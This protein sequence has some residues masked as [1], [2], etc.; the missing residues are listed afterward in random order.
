MARSEQDLQLLA[1]IVAVPGSC[2][3]RVQRT[4][5]QPDGLGVGVAAL[6][7]ACAARRYHAEASCGLTGL[8]EVAPRPDRSPCR[9]LGWRA[10]QRGR[11]ESGGACAGAAGL[12]GS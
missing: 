6:G 7:L 5:E 1:P 2:S 11:D 12:N 8:V 3:V 10:M 4:F 9:V